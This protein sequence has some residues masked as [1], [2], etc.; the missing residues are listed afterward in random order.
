MKKILI[1]LGIILVSFSVTSCSLVN[2][3]DSSGKSAYDIAVEHGF[4]GTEEE[5][6]ESLKGKDGESLHIAD[7][8][9]MW[10]QQGNT[11]TFDEFITKYFSETYFEGK[12]AYDLAVEAGFKGSKEEWIASLKGE[13]GMNGPAGEAIDL[14]E[15]YQTLRYETNEIDCSFLEF[16]QRYLN[17]DI[18]PSNEEAIAKAIK[19]AVKIVATNYTIFDSL[20]NVNTNVKIKNGAGV[21]YQINNDGDAYIITNFHVVYD[22]DLKQAH[23]NILINIYGNENL[24][25]SIPASFVGGSATYDIAVLYIDGDT[26]VLSS[27]FNET[28]LYARP[29]YKAKDVFSKNQSMAITY[30]DSNILL[31]GATAIAIGNPKGDGIAVTEGIVSVDSEYIYMEPL[32]T[33]KEVIEE[34]DLVRM[35]VMRIDAAV[36][37]GNSGGGLFNS[38]GELIGIVNAKTVS[39]SIDN[40]SYAIPSNIAIFVANNIIRNAKEYGYVIKPLVGIGM[41]TQDSY[42]K[43]DPTTKTTRLYETSVITTVDTT[44]PLFNQVR[45]GDIVKSITINGVTYEATRSFIVIDACLNADIGTT[46]IFKVLRNNVEYSYEFTFENAS[47]IK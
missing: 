30:E 42:S 36:N 23:K 5:W 3:G 19:S 47:E 26:G 31:P 37:P 45:V 21:I 8:Y 7:I 13:T 10:L 41:L 25:D 44:S 40:V 4:T 24:R 1:F 16:V 18:K 32:I 14:Y 43:Y 35:R 12:S 33:D 15:V 17:V 6:L 29:G 9:A 39:T 46:A 11:G 2:T 20:G 22:T 34:E 27:N 28:S 38:K